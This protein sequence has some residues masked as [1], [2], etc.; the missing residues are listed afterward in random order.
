MA[1]QNTEQ[2][3]SILVVDDDL[4]ILE[5]VK[6]VLEDDG[7]AVSTTHKMETARQ[8][9]RTI[10]FNAAVVDVMMPGIL[11]DSAAQDIEHIFDEDG[12]PN[13][14]TPIVVFSASSKRLKSVL[15]SKHT[16]FVVGLEKPFDVEAFSNLV[17][18]CVEQS[19][20]AL[21]PEVSPS[22]ES[23]TDEQ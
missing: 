14:N 23:K 10:F 19:F 4:S 20:P 15:D 13:A 7:Y 16:H 21:P 5:V 22:T 1:N 17:K 12:S 3:Y 2:P 11:G 18:Q 8:L 9:G 6:F